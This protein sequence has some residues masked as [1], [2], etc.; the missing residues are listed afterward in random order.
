MVQ[1]H[2]R[3]AFLVHTFPSL[4]QTFILGQIIG[5]VNRDCRIDIY[6]ERPGET[7]V[8]PDVEIY[9]LLERTRYS[10]V[11]DDYAW[12]AFKASG[13]LF[14]NLPRRGIRF[15]DNPMRRWYCMHLRKL[16]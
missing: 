5:L 2:M 3:V 16:K 14:A 11:P 1:S 8:H 12:R 9:R 15:R 10:S 6:A 13:L 4:S 7:L